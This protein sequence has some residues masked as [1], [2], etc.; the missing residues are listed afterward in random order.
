MSWATVR[1]GV[2]T[3]VALAMR[4]EDYAGAGGHTVQRV[5]WEGQEEASEWVRDDGAAVELQL[6]SIRRLH[7]DEKRLEIIA[8]ADPLLQVLRPIYTGTRLFTVR[9]RVDRDRQDDAAESMG[10][11]DELRTRWER[12]DVRAVLQAAEVA[13]QT[14]G[15]TMNADLVDLDGRQ[16]SVAV[17]DLFLITSVA[18]MD[19]VPTGDWIRTAQGDGEI[20]PA[21]S[22]GELEVDFDT[23]L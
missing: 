8:N 17:T 5:R 15:E 7:R 4:L 2:R 19:S 10:A 12:E 3:A 20:S 21:R 6:L 22:G 1:E 9:V 14:I 13:T 11:S 18:D 23:A 16:L